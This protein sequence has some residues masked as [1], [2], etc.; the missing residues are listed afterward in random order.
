[1]GVIQYARR[2]FARAAFVKTI[3]QTAVKELVCLVGGLRCELCASPL[4]ATAVQRLCG[5]CFHQL[6]AH[7]LDYKSHRH[8]VPRQAAETW[9]EKLPYI[10]PQCSHPL[11]VQGMPCWICVRNPLAVTKLYTLFFNTGL[12][13]RLLH[14]YKFQRHPSYA[15]LFAAWLSKRLAAELRRF[16]VCVPITLA[17]AEKRARRFCPVWTVLRP[18]MKQQGIALLPVIK[19]RPLAKHETHQHFKT[20]LERKHAVQARFSY[21]LS[22]Y[23]ALNGKRVL[24][25]DD[26]LTSGATINHVAG[27]INKHNAPR[28][29]AAFTFLRSVLKD[30]PLKW[31]MQQAARQRAFVTKSTTAELLADNWTIFT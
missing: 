14:C 24:I 26:V 13:Q 20:L 31:R 10:C 15:K 2:L 1:M 5:A 3:L 16:D 27:L 19:R 11:P 30:T 9:L 28:E 22:Q 21:E 25:V 6:S 7:R 18:A 17:P 4:T 12:P 29:V 23:G 8:S